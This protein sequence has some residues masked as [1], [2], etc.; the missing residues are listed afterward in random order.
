M[1]KFNEIIEQVLNESTKS[2]FSKDELISG[3]T[4]RQI[5]KQL[6]DFYISLNV[7]LDS[8]DEDNSKIT[9]SSKVIKTLET[10][11]NSVDDTIKTLEK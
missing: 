9:E 1:K 3:L 5:I 11:L 8:I 4:N 2:W 6:E 10:L 7:L